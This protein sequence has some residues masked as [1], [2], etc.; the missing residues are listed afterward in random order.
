MNGI[1]GRT[2]QVRTVLL[3]RL[4]GKTC[5]Q[6]TLADLANHD[7]CANANVC[8][9]LNNKSI[10]SLKAIDFYGLA[11]LTHVDLLNNAGLTTLPSRAFDGLDL[12]RLHLWGAGFTSL[13]SDAFAGMQAE[14]IRL[15][16]TSLTTLPAGLFSGVTKLKLLG[17]HGAGLTSLPATV[18]QGL[19]NLEE[20][21]LHVNKFPTLPVGV[22]KG[23]TSLKKLL[24]SHNYEL[25]ALPQKVFDGLSG[26]NT[27]NVSSTGLICLPDLPSGATVILGAGWDEL[28]NR[29]CRPNAP[30]SVSITP[31]H[32]RLA[33]DWEPPLRKSYHGSFTGY[34]L[35]HRA[36]GGNWTTANL[37]AT[38]TD[39]LLTGL[40]NGTAYQVQVRTLNDLGESPWSA[41][42]TGTPIDNRLT[43]SK[44][45]VSPPEG[46]SETFTMALS[47]APEA[48]VT[49]TVTRSSGDTDLSADADPDTTGVQNSV[50]FE[51]SD[52]NSA[53]TVA[54]LAAEDDDH[55]DGSGVFTVALTSSGDSYFD[56]TS[57]TVNATEDDN[58][59]AALVLNPARVSVNEGATGSYAVALAT[60][61]TGGNVTV[62]VS[63]TS[64]DTDL[65][66]SSGSSLTFTSANW[67]TGQTV[68]LRAAEDGDGSSDIAVF[69]HSA[70]GADYAGTSA[71]IT[72]MEVDNDAGLT[73]SRA[74]LSVAEGGSKSYTVRLNTQPTADVTVEVARSS[75]D[76]DLTV[77]AGSSLTFTTT[78]WSS[79]QT[80]T[81]AAASDSDGADG[82]ATITHTPSGGDYG[83]GEAAT[84]TVTEDDDDGAL[85]LSATKLSVPEGSTA[86]YKVRLAAKPGG[87]VTVAVAIGSGDG[88]LSV[89]AGS[90]LAFTTTDWNTDQEVTLAAAQDVDWINGTATVTHTASGNGYDDVTANLTATEADDERQLTLTP[91]T[92]TVPEG[93]QAVYSVRLSSR[94]DSTVVVTIWRATGG[95]TDLG[96][97]GRRRRGPGHCVHYGQLERAAGNSHRGGAGRR[98]PQRQRDVLARRQRWGLQ[99][100]ERNFDGDRGGRRARGGSLQVDR[101]G[102]RGGNAD[103]HGEARDPARRNGDGHA[104]E[105]ERRGRRSH[106]RYGF[107]RAWRPGHV[108]LYD[109]G[110]ELGEDGDPERGFGH[111]R[112]GG[113]G[114][115]HA[116][117]VGR[118]L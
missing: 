76:T 77:S 15:D 51:T 8:I 65:S 44:S 81:I 117:G 5:G 3:N 16:Q 103:V 43:L 10:T 4:A 95:D 63:R 59:A 66:V 35:R 115:L 64:G 49:A 18:F 61:P 96:D 107:G 30:R 110:L 100:E 7:D 92:L 86:K 69:T 99:R 68:V 22:F 31:G 19:T 41:T 40:T 74:S 93:G 13:P 42:T 98:R 104:D 73:L 90:S 112:P 72:A 28:H 20:L 116:C 9:D 46:S 34:D 62:S 32:N 113:Q 39:K 55:D 57:G 11:H 88:D 118:R 79:A 21:Q 52:W 94:P 106:G 58:D 6:V 102:A 45:S 26:I 109:D 101:R 105:G 91:S 17:L 50:T 12:K 75:G 111:G 83:T 84:L 71:T 108:E 89:S 67:N 97:Q 23:L 85:I 27:I 60:Q 70:S 24:L 38:P 48:T 14:R 2:Q 78:N 47:H 114:D 56:G 87:N 25:V 36:V 80:V 29:P 54:V 82:S 33:V 37:S 53:R 1:C